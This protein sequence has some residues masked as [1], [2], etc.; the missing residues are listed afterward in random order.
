MRASGNAGPLREETEEGVDIADGDW[1]NQEAQQIIDF[2]NQEAEGCV[3][4]M[5]N[6]ILP[7]QPGDLTA[8]L[9]G[10]PDPRDYPNPEQMP[11]WRPPQN[12]PQPYLPFQDDFAAWLSILLGG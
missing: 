3:E 12:G 5:G 6:A 7:I 10:P 11:L 8:L 9:A 2:L 1:H 4:F